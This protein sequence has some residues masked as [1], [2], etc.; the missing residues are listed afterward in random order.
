MKFNLGDTIKHVRS[1]NVYRITGTP[2]P[3][4]G[5]R[6]QIE[7][8]NEPAY[9]Y[10]NENGVVW[11]RSQTKMEDGRFDLDSGSPDEAGSPQG[12]QP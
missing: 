2:E 4:D 8:T 1:G 12:V 11:I 5:V 7:P 10:T 6:Y 3:T 9:A